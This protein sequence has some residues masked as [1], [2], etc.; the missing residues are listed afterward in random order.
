MTSRRIVFVAS[1]FDPVVPGGAGSVVAGLMERLGLPQA[2]VILLAPHLPPAELD[3]NSNLIWVDTP[4]PDGSLEWFV[5]RSRLAAT[6]LSD[7]VKAQGRPDLVEF[8]DFE[9]LGWWA[10]THRSELGLDD[11][12][13]AIRIHGPVEAITDAVGSRPAP[14]DVVG[15]MERDAL[16]MA[17]MLLVPSQAMGDWAI[18]RY[19]LQLARVI[20]APPPIPSV[21]PR[22]WQPSEDPT[23]VFYGRLAEAKGVHDLAAALVPVLDGHPDVHV[24]FIGADGWSLVDKRPMSESLS[25]L[26]PERHRHRVE[27]LG[28]LDREEAFDRLATAWAAVFPSRFESFCLACH[29]ARRVGTP[30][31]VPDLPAFERFGESTG[32]LKYDGSVDSL[33]RT[34]SMVVENRALVEPLAEKPAPQVGD[35]IAPYLGSIPAVRHTNAQAAMATS[36]VNRL[37]DSM[38][39]AGAGDGGLAQRLLRVLPRPIVRFAARVLPRGVKDRFRASALW[40]E[41]EARRVAVSRRQ[42]LLAMMAAATFPEEPSPRA[43]IVIPCFNQGE[44]VER[45]V[46]SVFEQTEPSWEVVLVDD[47]STDQVTITVLDEL[48]EWPRV[49]L[50]RQENRGLPGARNAGM[51]VSAGEFLVPLDADDELAPEY[52]ETLIAALD[53]EPKAGYAH[54]WGRYTDNMN[55][56][57]ITRPFNRYQI[58]LSNSVLGCA[59]IRAEAWRSVEGYDESLIE[60]NEDWDLWLRLLERGWAEVEVRSPLFRYRMHGNSM[61]VGTLAGFEE[62]RLGLRDRHPALYGRGLVEATKSTWYPWVTVLHL[63]ERAVTKGQDLLDVEEA[64]IEAG[65]ESIVEALATSH[66]K[67]VIEWDLLLDPPLSALRLIADALESSS[68]AG[69]AMA[70]GIPVAWRRWLLHDPEAPLAEKVVV[71]LRV[72]PGEEPRLYTGIAPL[73]DWMV[74]AD[75]PEPGLRVI[76]QRPEEEGPLPTWL[77]G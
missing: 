30:V 72:K 31:I 34:L 19:G 6:T 18:R 54:C 53:L 37:E 44:W 38:V 67:V 28:R 12:R 58:L 68:A 42:A 13:I 40:W 50:I 69:V 61:S 33:T 32:A 57:W 9:A 59:T 66:G 2:S 8:Q 74:P 56:Y 49:R 21:N 17:D 5:E 60:G 36:A 14:L 35:A 39:G 25:S 55:A 15:A 65:L 52:L 48:A 16:S 46:L 45:A 75:L 71:D 41:E 11:V 76:R 73:S 62:A 64:G 10:L 3:N 4:E 51:S 22:L 27:M 29:E 26:I 70:D 63:G 7:H 20:E 43:S 1:E 47:G 24:M 23:L 77:G